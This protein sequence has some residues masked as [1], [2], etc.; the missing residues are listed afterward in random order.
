MYQKRTHNKD[1]I[2]DGHNIEPRLLLKKRIMKTNRG[3]QVK[4]ISKCVNNCV[5]L[6]Y[7][8]Q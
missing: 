7:K 3:H 8:L 5:Q 6:C 4:R 2:I 1:G